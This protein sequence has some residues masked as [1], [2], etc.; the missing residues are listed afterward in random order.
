[1]NFNFFVNIFTVAVA[2]IILKLYFSIFFEKQK[3]HQHNPLFW[4]I[5]IIWQL[6]FM[7]CTSIPSSFKLILNIILVFFICTY[8]FTGNIFSKIVVSILIC[9]IWTIQEF[10][11]GAFFLLINLNI[12]NLN[13]I[14][15]V[16]SKILTLFLVVVLRQFF[17]NEKVQNIPS[18]YYILITLI[19]AGSLYIM[20]NIFYLCGQSDQKSVFGISI[21]SFLII[22]AM[23]LVIFKVYILLAQEFEIRHQNTIYIQQLKAFEKSNAER[24]QMQSTFK[25][26]RHDFKQ[27]Y[28]ILSKLLKESQYEK[29]KDYMDSLKIISPENNIITSKTGNFILDTLINSKFALIPNN[30]S[31]DLLIEVNVP[32]VLPFQAADLGILFGN[33]L[34]NAIEAT[35]QNDNIKKYIRLFARYENQT[36]II[37]CINSFKHV[38]N[39]TPSGDF[40][41]TK[42]NATDHGYGIYS[43]KKVAIKYH[44]SV[45]IDYTEDVFTIKILLCDL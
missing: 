14:G 29:A 40:K 10:L 33:I 42:S 21:I 37:T 27:H 43:I 19:P 15:S 32:P 13:F 17:L 35:L 34:D 11:I 4:I 28:S 20:Y 2:I 23:N 1:M 45:L 12:T 38:L 30:T 7:N 31:I 5:Y 6:F 22:L 24:E 3:V 26:M 25:K 16:L 18:K 41:T 9:S 39:V 44:G 8:H 36:L